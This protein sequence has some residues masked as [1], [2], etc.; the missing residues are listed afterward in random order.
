MP[1]KFTKRTQNITTFSI[2]KHSKLTQIGILGLKI[3]HL[4]ALASGIRKMLDFVMPH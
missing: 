1:G 4:A 2:A 3:Y